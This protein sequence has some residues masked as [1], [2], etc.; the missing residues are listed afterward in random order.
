MIIKTE[1]QGNFHISAVFYKNITSTTV[2]PVAIYVTRTE[3]I[4]SAVPTAQIRASTL[5]LLG[6]LI[7]GNRVLRC[8]GGVH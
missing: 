2:A 8:L 4:A 5:L 1:S 7:A 6:L 3:I